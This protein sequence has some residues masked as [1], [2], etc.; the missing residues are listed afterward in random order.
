ML[1]PLSVQKFI[2]QEDQQSDRL[3]HV[4]FAGVA[5]TLLSARRA[6]LFSF[7]TV[8]LSY[9]I[10]YLFYFV[11]FLPKKEKNQEW[12]EGNYTFFF[13]FTLFY[14]TILYWFCHTLTWNYTFFKFNY[15]NLTT[16]R[17]IKREILTG[18]LILFF[19]CGEWLPL[20]T[21]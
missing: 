18:Q 3:C 11:S 19:H 2:I 5:T 4:Q 13:F 15:K 14:F 10:L 16:Q 12:K 8:L 7:S 6:H 1:S 17:W 21:H 20:V 9:T